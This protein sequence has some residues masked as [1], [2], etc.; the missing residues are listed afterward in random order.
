MFLYRALA[1]LRDPLV[2]EYGFELIERGM[3]AESE[4]EKAK[5]IGYGMNIWAK[6]YEEEDCRRVFD[7]YVSLPDRENDPYE[8]NHTVDF[9]ITHNM[10]DRKFSDPRTYGHLVW[11]IDNT[12]CSSCRKQAVRILSEHGMLQTAVREYCLLDCDTETRMI[13]ENTEPI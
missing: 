5:L 13:A 9:A 11:I 10:F 6:N 1:R 3:A 4:S 7:L 2:R 8:I 12:F